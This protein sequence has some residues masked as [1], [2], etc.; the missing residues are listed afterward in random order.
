MTHDRYFP[1]EDPQLDRAAD[2]LPDE[3][4]EEDDESDELRDN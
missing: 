3:P 4:E 2:D 1:G